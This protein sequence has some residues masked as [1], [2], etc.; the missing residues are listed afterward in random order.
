M[1]IQRKS[2]KT[3]NEKNTKYSIYCY[4]EV[5]GSEW[6]ITP[7]ILQESNI[8][9]FIVIFIWILVNL[10]SFN[11][12]RMGTNQ[13]N[14]EFLMAIMKIDGT[15]VTSLLALLEFTLSVKFISLTIIWYRLFF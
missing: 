6:I 7:Y 5:K 8:I 11:G 13:H 15:L 14:R 10:I 9:S 1:N 12:H 2:Q 3:S 4:I